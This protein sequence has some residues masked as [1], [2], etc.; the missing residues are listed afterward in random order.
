MVSNPGAIVSMTTVPFASSLLVIQWFRR[1]L[2]PRRSP[3]PDSQLGRRSVTN[4]TNVVVTCRRL[5]QHIYRK[6]IQF[7]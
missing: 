6:M 5:W 7:F 3:R 2:N 4:R 1:A